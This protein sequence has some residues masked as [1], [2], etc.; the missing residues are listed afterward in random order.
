LPCH[1]IIFIIK[2]FLFSFVLVLILILHYFFTVAILFV[3]LFLLFFSIRYFCYVFMSLNT[4]YFRSPCLLHLY[5]HFDLFYVLSFC[6]LWFFCCYH[7]YISL[8]MMVLMRL[9]CL[10]IVKML[11][12]HIFFQKGSMLQC[13]TVTYASIRSTLFLSFVLL[14]SFLYSSDIFLYH[15]FTSITSFVYPRSTLAR[16]STLSL[17]SCSYIYT[18]YL[19][20]KRRE[21]IRT[22][23]THSRTQS[24][25]RSS[26]ARTLTFGDPG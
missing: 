12:K 25:R 26:R 2:N 5:V 22:F 4:F 10:F 23:R 8:S 24:V 11:M 1:F 20:N 15:V 18:R 17:F 9:S 21:K 14:I 13:I 3:L 7:C 6:F 19:S 16:L